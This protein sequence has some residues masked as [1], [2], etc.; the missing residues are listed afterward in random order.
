MSLRLLRVLLLAGAL[1]VPPA[2]AQFYW[3]GGSV[4]NNRWNTANNWTANST[5]PQIGLI[6]NFGADGQNN[7]T[8]VVQGNY[9]MSGLHFSTYTDWFVEPFDTGATLSFATG[10]I[11]V[12]DGGT[13][14]ISVPT[15]VAHP[16]TWYVHDGAL[17][18]A[19]RVYVPDSGETLTVNVG[20]ADT[21]TFFG[22]AGGVFGGAI[23]GNGN[24]TKTGPG[25]LEFQ[26]ALNLTGTLTVSAG[27][28]RIR[29]H[30][31]PDFTDLD[32]TNP[33]VQGTPTVSV[34]S[35][36]SFDLGNHSGT[37]RSVSGTGQM[38]VG[39]GRLTLSPL[40]GSTA[41]FDGTFS[42][43]ATGQ[44]IKASGGTFVWSPPNTSD[45]IGGDVV[46]EAGT[47]RLDGGA[48]LHVT[49]S[50]L[51]VN[52]GTFDYNGI[53][54]SIGSL[55]GTGGTLA[56]GAGTLTAGNDDTSTTF[57]GAITGTGGFTKTGTGTLTLSGSSSY[58]GATRVQEGTL[59][60][61][62]ANRLSDSS[63]LVVSSGA[64]F[65][66]G[67]NAGYFSETVGSL[68]GAGTVALGF[69]ALTVGGDNTSTTFSGQ[70][71]GGSGVL[72]KTGTGTLTLTGT[73][74][75]YT[76]GTTVSA[77]G[78]LAGDSR[79][80][81]GNIANEGTVLFT[82]TD[83]GVT[84]ASTVSGVLSG[85]G[86]FRVASGHTLTVSGASTYTGT[87]DILAGATVSQTVSNRLSDTGRVAV[88][89]TLDFSANVSDTV[90]SI[91]G[92]GTV[93]LNG[94]T[95]R[96]GGDDTTATFSGAFT[97]S[98][99]LEKLGTGIATLSG[100]STA[101]FS[102][103]TISAGS[104]SIRPGALSNTVATAITNNSHLIYGWT[105]SATSAQNVTGSGTAEKISTGTLTL[106]GTLASTGTF[107]INGGSVLLG[108]A[109]RI[110]DTTPVAVGATSTFNLNGYAD[111]IGPLSGSGSVNLSGGALTVNLPDYPDTSAH[112]GVISGSGDF[113]K[114]GHGTLTLSGTNT[115]I[116]T[117][118]LAAGTLAV[119]ADSRLGNAANGVEFTGGTL[120]QTAAFN[121]ARTLV[122]GT[123]GG[124]I[125]TGGFNA[126]WSGSASGS[127]AFTKAG[128][129]TLTLTGAFAHTGGT[130]VDGG[131]LALGAADRLADTGNVGVNTG[132][133]FALNNFS[134]TIAGLSG[135]GAVT[136]GSATLT[137]GTNNATSSWS[138]AI[139]GIGGLTKIGTG[140]LTVSGNN[141]FT[142]PLALSGGTL[143]LSGSERFADTVAA[144]LGS[145]T[146]FALAGGTE[147]LG[148]VA[149]T[150]TVG[151][152]GGT[153]AV[154]GGNA[155]FTLSAALAAASVGSASSG[156]T[157][158]KTGGG[159]LTLGAGWAAADI[160]LDVAAGTVALGAAQR[161]PDTAAVAVASGATLAL[162]G[163]AETV[164]PLT[165]AGSVTLGGGAFGVSV[166]SGQGTATFTGTV[167]GS[168]SFAKSGTGTLVLGGAN[169]Y[170]GPTTV[171][172]GTLR[173]GTDD[174]LPT[175]TA[176]TVFPD[177]SFD[178][179]GRTQSVGSLAGSGDVALGMGGLLYAGG[180]G[181]STAHSGAISGAGAFVKQGGG[182]LMLGGTSTYSGNTQITGGV[183]QFSAAANLG[184]GNIFIDGAT[185][186][187]SAGNTADLSARLSGT[188]FGGGTL[189]V[190]ANTV[191]FASALGG[192]GRYTKAGSGTLV[193][194]ATATHTGGTTVAAGTLQLGTGGTARGLA[195]DV[196]VASG[197]T[198]AFNHATSLS[199]APAIT[200]AGAVSKTG[201]GTLTLSSANSHAGGTMIAAGT[202]S[203]AHDEAAGTGPITLGGG[204][205]AAAS[206]PRTLANALVL[207]ADGTISGQNLTITGGFTL[208]RNRDLTIANTKTVL[209]GAI[210]E[211]GGPR[212]LL[213]YGPGELELLGASTYTGGTTIAAG[214]VRINNPSG[215]VFGTGAVTVAAGATL[216]GAGSFTGP[217][218]VSG[219]FSPGNSPGLATIGSGSILSGTTLMELAGLTRGTTYDAVNV[220]G[221][222][223]ITF[224]GTLQVV[225]LDSFVP[226]GG[227]SFDL[228]NFATASGTFSTL[229]LPALAGGLSWDTSALYSAGVL[230]VAGSAIPEPSTYAACAGLA[231]LFLAWHRRRGRRVA[232]SF[233]PRSPT[234]AG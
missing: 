189:D 91:T 40:V 165:G 171:S 181:T 83:G 10:G 184:T 8:S 11:S 43:Q 34:A 206:A 160:A 196:A 207:D 223:T 168:G 15:T 112:S 63:A 14:R 163:F 36:A 116:G 90:G 201:S 146:T 104:L 130:G 117:T 118:R 230:S 180:D 20:T 114:I 17:T 169:T 28:L 69:G 224:G 202:L 153:L 119:G 6:A 200:G 60:L 64:T 208:A 157:L 150:G 68:A 167:S 145:G 80:I 190:G 23:E 218:Q 46:V 33:V 175:G 132:A 66:L 176:L 151:F 162:G 107:S 216:T 227:A 225:L 155:S 192:S 65:A 234:G 59:K 214:T 140:T 96:F 5:P 79:S 101:T 26:R 228:F 55:S 82:T 27:T 77:G 144:T 75:T 123:G 29:A 170:A 220:D 106:S 39:L 134:E 124:T 120:Q 147:T 93:D 135:T 136:L 154:G 86:T 22:S 149:G 209:T 42:V 72:N 7:P 78:T 110:G 179:A 197:A 18:M 48:G 211:T 156:G 212:S 3:D 188:G 109:N 51:T 129:G 95:F 37:F 164:G 47:F 97:G 161:I 152:G 111:T 210:V 128:S 219:T 141:T 30:T 159:T 142:G 231:A 226:G 24:L 85:D 45:S 185:L 62:A 61:V 56:L 103:V 113:T 50:R 12:S 187:W 198:L 148:S 232:R 74:N 38:V 2:H 215:S 126:T 193:L 4:L 67:D 32:L 105:S 174:A 84:T 81:R 183:L 199:F 100:A 70:I 229:T 53:S 213:K 73:N 194:D 71:T 131:T 52:G 177:A 204:A 172:G 133:T 35:G 108:A 173:A 139:S 217:M 115:Y 94:G 13:A 195:S 178:L 122:F 1:S 92:A 205:L 222:G 49:D 25:L 127:G 99:A 76:G 158:R 16:Q 89:G 58:T 203:L 221:A 121:S 125:D 138:G 143:R 41:T 21:A 88:A 87:L 31:S 57:A 54:D 186:R 233:S 102:N 9:S 137:V 19:A 166:S 191:T 98:G 182:T 44:L